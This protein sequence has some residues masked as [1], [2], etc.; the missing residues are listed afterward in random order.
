MQRNGTHPMARI[1]YAI[2]A[3]SFGYSYVVL[4]IH[5]WERGFGALFWLALALQFLVYPHLAYLHAL[6]AENSRR[7]EG[8]NVFVDAALL[9]LWIGALHFPPWIAYGAIFS[10]SLNAAVMYGAMRAGW[11]VA[12]FCAGAAVGLAFT[13][14][15]FLEET[16][17]LV[18][19]LCFAGSLGYTVAV[20]GIVRTLRQQVRENRSQYQLLAENAADLIAIVDRESRWVYTSPSFDTVLPEWDRAA[21]MSAFER[22]HPDDDAAKNA[23]LRAAATGKARE[24]ALRLVDAEG[25]VRRYN[26][27]VQPVKG[28]PRPVARLV[29]TLR[30]VTDLHVSEE[31]LLIT[32][33]A[34]EGM[35][36]AIMIT[37][38]DGTIVTVNRAFTYITGHARDD[39][40]GQP[41]PTIRNALQP[42]DFFDAA[43]AAVARDGHWSGTSWNRRK[44]GTVYRE[45]RSIRATK[46]AAG[47]ITH[48][49]HVF[50]EVGAPRNGVSAKSDAA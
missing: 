33:H 13:G 45:W 44:N 11:S 49:I 18:T 30:D 43:Y 50:Y 48:Y 8:I 28:E 41:E 36:E 31:K 7:A 2:R 26:A 46:D 24:L 47:A 3:A 40:V 6:R 27:L 14:F 20:G 39:V 37:A 10:T 16:S 4:A 42:S 22:A 34:L 25:R 5:G 29:L 17:P 32:A 35:T 12:T 38:A 9:G 23:V 21:G 1:N 15:Q 19:A